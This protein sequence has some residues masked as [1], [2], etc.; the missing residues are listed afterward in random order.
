MITK[1]ISHMKKLLMRVFSAMILTVTAVSFVSCDFLGIGI[2]RWD[3][4][5]WVVT[6][7][8]KAQNGIYQVSADGETITFK[9]K[10][11][12]GPWIS[13][14]LSGNE[15]YY[16]HSEGCEE[17]RFASDW[18]LA[19]MSGDQLRIIFEPNN[20]GKERPLELSVT[21]GDI[22]HTFKFNQKAK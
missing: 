4:M 17:H 18:F 2:G 22:F 16:L 5:K 8:Q 1:N 20:T 12:E 10:N 19:T 7:G 3:K 21:G 6:S 13:Y 11:Y 9:C 14:A 15:S